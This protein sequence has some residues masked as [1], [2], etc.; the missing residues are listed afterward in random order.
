MRYPVAQGFYPWNKKELLSM[1]NFLFTKVDKTKLPSFSNVLG[2]VVP[3]AG[4][5]YS[6]VTAAHFYEVLK[7]KDIKKV[8]IL[9]TNHT[10]LGEPVSISREDWETPLGVVPVDL[11][12]ADALMEK[13]SVFKVDEL[14]HLYEHSIEVQLPFLQYTLQDFTFL[15][16]CITS[17][18]HKNLYAEVGKA[19]SEVMDESTV[20]IASSDFTHFGQGY[21][22]MPVNNY[23]VEWVRKTDMKA[24]EAIL[25]L[26]VDD[27]L[28]IAKETTICGKGAIASL[29]CTMK[30]FEGVEGKLIHYSTSYDVSGNEDMIVGYASIGFGLR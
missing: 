20:L 22:F 16:I 7:G 21:G 5:V 11:E 2:G 27:F 12:L 3:H 29:M 23:G 25:S 9:G 1:L 18:A 19:I 17:E 28:S 26:D 6:G 13:S 15:P 14:A 10:G 8:I 30:Y 4:Y 24:I